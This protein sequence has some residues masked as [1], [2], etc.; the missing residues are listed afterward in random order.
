MGRLL[1]EAGPDVGGHGGE[2]PRIGWLVRQ[3]RVPESCA[4]RRS[5]CCASSR[6]RDVPMLATRLKRFALERFSPRWR[7]RIFRA[8]GAVLPSWLESSARFGAIDMARTLA[9]SDE[10]NYFPRCTSTWWAASRAACVAAC[11]LA[12]RARARDGG[13]AVACAIRFRGARSSRACTR[14]K[15][16][17]RG[18]SWSARPTCCSS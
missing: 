13:L 3:G 10:L 7:D 14:V 9:F 15:S 5:V 6:S 16:C 1:R 18:P 4:R 12:G 8:G 2:R 17:S 11:R